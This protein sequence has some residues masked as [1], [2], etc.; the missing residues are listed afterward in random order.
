MV[1]MTPPN[2]AVAA[3][4]VSMAAFYEFFKPLVA[5]CLAIHMLS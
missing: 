4:Q 3:N 1:E 5:E 2:L